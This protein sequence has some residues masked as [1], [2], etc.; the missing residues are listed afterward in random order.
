MTVSLL[1][2]FYFVTLLIGCGAAVHFN[3]T[4]SPIVISNSDPVLFYCSLS[5]FDGLFLSIF[6]SVNNT[7]LPNNNYTDLNITGENTPSSAL[8]IPALP[9]FNNTVVGCRAVGVLTG[10]DSYHNEANSTLLIQ[11]TLYSVIFCFQCN[12]SIG[13]YGAVGNLSCVVQYHIMYCSWSPPFSLIPIPNHVINITNVH[14]QTV[15]LVTNSVT[16]S[17]PLNC[18]GNYTINVAG[19]NTAGVGNVSTF[20]VNYPQSE[21]LFI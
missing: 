9:Q 13:V 2:L 19:N 16:L 21:I 1:A 20:N 5:N 15:K 17:Y 10:G 3:F 18:Y 6:W 4:P 11:G 14:N 7:S 12:K 8:S